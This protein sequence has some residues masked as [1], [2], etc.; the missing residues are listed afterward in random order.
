[1]KAMR[2]KLS[3]LKNGGGNRNVFWRPQD[4]DQDIRIVS[5]EDGDPFKDFYFHYNVENL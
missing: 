3:A 1:M 4:G 2:A 5:P